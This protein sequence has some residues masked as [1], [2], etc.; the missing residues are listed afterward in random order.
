M[1]PTTFAGDPS[2]AEHASWGAGIPSFSVFLW[3]NPWEGK[4]QV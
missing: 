2:M 3:V 1:A 4:G